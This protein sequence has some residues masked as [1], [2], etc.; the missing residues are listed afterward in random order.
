MFKNF[1]AKISNL[2]SVLKGN[3]NANQKRWIPLQRIGVTA[4]CV[5]W[6]RIS[7]EK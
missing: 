2:F 6:D 5:E 3:H 1:K 4:G 7:N